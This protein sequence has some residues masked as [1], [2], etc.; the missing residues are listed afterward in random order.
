MLAVGVLIVGDVGNIVEGVA[1]K[2]ALLLIVHHLH[3]IF[4]QRESPLV[5]FAGHP[6]QPTLALMHVHETKLITIRYH[7]TLCLHMTL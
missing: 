5:Q 4:G 7:K 3:S 2:D 1:R 6:W